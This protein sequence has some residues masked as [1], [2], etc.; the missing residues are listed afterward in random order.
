[1]RQSNFLSRSLAGL[2][3]GTCHN[4]RIFGVWHVHG[5]QPVNGQR[6]NRP[7]LVAGSSIVPTPGIVPA[8]GRSAS[9]PATFFHW[10]GGCACHQLSLP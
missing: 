10:P 9:P 7:S 1:M 5:W 3:P 2:T 6:P 4:F 8:Y